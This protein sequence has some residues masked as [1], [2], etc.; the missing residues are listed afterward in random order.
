MKEA[1]AVAVIAAVDSGQMSLAQAREH[2]G[3]NASTFWRMRERFRRKGTEGLAH[4]LRGRSGNRKADAVV[5]DA[6]CA[7]YRVEYAPHG[8]GARHFWEEASPQ[9]PRPVPYSTTWN[10]LRQAGLTERSRRSVKHR[11]RR[12]RRECFGALVQMDTSIHDWFST[13][14]KACLVSA[15]DDATGNVIGAYFNKT[16]TVLANMRVMKS[17]FEEHGLPIEFYVDRSPIFKF[18]RTGFGRVMRHKADRVVVTQVEQA[19]KT[20]GIELIHAYTPQAKGRIERSFGT[21]QARLVPELA[22]VGILAHYGVTAMPC[23]VR[24][25]DRKGKVERGVDQAQRT[26]LKGLRFETLDAAQ[27][28]LD[29]WETK[30]ADTRIH[31]TIKRQVAEMFAKERPHLQSLPLELFRY[32]SHGVRSVLFDGCV[33]VQAAYYSA[34]PALIAQQVSVQWDDACVQLS[35]SAQVNF[36]ASTRALSA[37]VATFRGPTSPRARLC[38]PFSSSRAQEALV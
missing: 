11:S 20:L 27:A 30:C 23:R 4:G 34:L 18:T 16:D 17:I 3:V 28:C 35:N 1:K 19:L 22:K 21:W 12:P 29:R 13:G 32:C 9:F 2:L 6:V 31:G 24:D 10:W 26:P 15:I 37:D 7:L 36:C 38:R 8:F 25:P 33:E 14:E 5:R